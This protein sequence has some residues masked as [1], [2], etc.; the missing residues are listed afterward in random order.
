M[1]V[2][3]IL[4]AFALGVPAQAFG[5][6][7]RLRVTQEPGGDFT[8]GYNS[9][10]D[11]TDYWCAAGNFVTNVMALPD[12]TRV[13]RKSPPPRKAGQGISFTLDASRSAGET[14]LS[15]FGGLQDGS[16]SA[17]GAFAQFCFNYVIEDF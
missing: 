4:L 2:L 10:A 12:R 8:V 16:M 6:E 3:P 5:T 9:Q 14:G 7:P 13:Y 11:I 15:T 17:G 1:R